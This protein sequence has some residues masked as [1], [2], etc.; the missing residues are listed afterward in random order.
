M[1]N[2]EIYNITAAAGENSEV[3]II[4]KKGFDELRPIPINIS[5]NID[6]V[7]NWLNCRFA[8]GG[9]LE[10]INTVSRHTA[11]VLINRDKM[12]ISLVVN[13]NDPYFKGSVTGAL[14]KHPDF[15]KWEINTGKEWDNKV[16]AD[17]IKMNRNCF[18]SKGN[19]MKLS[20]ELSTLKVKVDNEV[21]KA[22]DN[23]GNVRQMFAQKVIEMNIPKTFI[24]NVPVFKGQPTATFEVEIYVNPNNYM[25]SL[26]SP[27]ANDIV[28][29]IRDSVIDDQKTNIMEIAHG[30]VIIEQ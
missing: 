19:A 20:A 5:G 27:E 22:N 17:F 4:H 18:E 10:S 24:L 25:V 7:F 3:V 14:T 28:S 9:E 11:H 23:R 1:E 16:L 21:E 8:K 30:L 12:T 15:E 13:E 26:V 6:S 2:Q 29:M